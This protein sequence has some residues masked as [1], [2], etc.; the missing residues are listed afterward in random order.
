LRKVVFDS[1]FLIG[2]VEKPTTWY[3][4]ILEKMGKF[5][6]VIL[7][8]VRAELERLAQGET[9][10]ARFAALALELTKEFDVERC[11]G[12]AVDDEIASYGA[13]ARAIVATV[14]AALLKRLR[15]TRVDAITLRS[16]RVAVS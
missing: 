2:V 3:E 7:D 13:S 10:R 11:G 4:D 14:D 5:E 16:G 12:L 1:S 15:R 9:R 8:C 6:P